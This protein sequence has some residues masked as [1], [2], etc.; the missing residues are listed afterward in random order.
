M[1]ACKDCKYHSRKNGY[2]RH[3][4]AIR[5]SIDVPLI[6]G[7]YCYTSYSTC[8]HMR[9]SGYC[10]KKGML[11]EPKPKRKKILGIF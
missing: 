1:N 7:I 11:F 4:I 9:F 6:D 8:E 10:G 3:E 5:E 2:C